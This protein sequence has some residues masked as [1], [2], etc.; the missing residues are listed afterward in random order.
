MKSSRTFSNR[1]ESVPEARH[2]T[3]QLLANLPPRTLDG[4]SLM[5]SELATNCIRHAGAGFRLTVEVN[6]Q[7]IHVAVTDTGGGEPSL[8]FP[9]PTEPSGRGLQIIQTLSEDWG[10]EPST[11]TVGKTVWFTHPLTAL[12]DNPAPTAKPSA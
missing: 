6:A 11:A 7:R 2:F 3:A 5:V 12:T 10:V 4:V 8:R 9:G 1:A